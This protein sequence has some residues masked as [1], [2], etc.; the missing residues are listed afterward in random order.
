M[1]ARAFVTLAAC[2]LAAAVAVTAPA[3]ARPVLDAFAFALA[4][5]AAAYVAGVAFLAAADA[6]DAAAAAARPRALR[7]TGRLAFRV[8]R[9][10]Y[11][12]AR[13]E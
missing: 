1:L 9:A 6:V 4:A 2:F 10:C 8:A 7:A 12:A 3:W 13:A 5:S 11:A